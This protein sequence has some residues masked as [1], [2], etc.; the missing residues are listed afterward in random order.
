MMATNEYLLVEQ[1][2][3]GDDRAYRYLYDHH[4]QVLCHVAEMYLHDTF[5]AESVVGDVI[6]HLWE[7]RQS[8]TIDTSLRSYL[9][10]CVKNK[11]LDYL[12]SDYYQR[13]DS[14]SAL[15]DENTLDTL[16]NLTSDSNACEQLI[17]H[18]LEGEIADAIASLPAECKRV[19]EMSRFE[20]KKYDE[21]AESVGI[22]VNTVK[23]HIKHALSLLSERLSPI[24]F[25]ALIAYMQ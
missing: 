4:Y 23:Y 12:K 6:F 15:P 11:C 2:R 16:N 7:I 17:E 22:S 5:M 8:L 13:V 19:F 3:Q 25:V 24:L 10:T 21:I 9:L 18:E 1:L 20:G 14:L